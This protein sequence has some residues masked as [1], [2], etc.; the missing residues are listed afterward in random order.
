MS[1]AADGQ[2]EQRSGMRWWNLATWRFLVTSTREGSGSPTGESLTWVGLARAG[3][4]PGD[5]T[6]APISSYE[7][8][9]EIGQCLAGKV[10]PS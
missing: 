9:Q 6:G 2:T 7:E 8:E 5:D 1:N 3:E 4:V 10:E